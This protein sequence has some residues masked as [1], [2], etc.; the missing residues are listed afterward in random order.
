MG[1][2][3]YEIVKFRY[4]LANYSDCPGTSAHIAYTAQ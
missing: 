4:L 1:V 3:S 2:L